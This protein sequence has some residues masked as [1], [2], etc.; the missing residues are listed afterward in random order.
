MREEVECI[1]AI[2]GKARGERDEDI[3]EWIVF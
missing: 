1:Q 2:G 3:G